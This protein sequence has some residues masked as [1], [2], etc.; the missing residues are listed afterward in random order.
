M[1]INLANYKKDEIIKMNAWKCPSHSHTGLEHPQC[2]LREHG[3]DLK[4]CFFDLESTSLN[5]TFGF[6]LTYSI[7][8]EGDSNVITGT[9]TKKEVEDG[10]YDK[11]IVKECIDALMKFDR[12]YT[13]YGSRFDLPLLRTRALEQGV[14]F[15]IYGAMSQKDIYYIAKYKLKLHSNRLDCVCDLLNISGK[16]HINPKIWR[17]A[18][19]GNKKA[20]DAI[21]E[22]NIADVEVLELVYNKLK[23]FVKEDNKSI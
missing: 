21:L 18:S 15:P 22:H 19:G 2:Y 16:T 6:I 12:V 23:N 9:V 11:R 8:P 3:K 1:T 13:Y 7:K 4:R 17:L 20:I 10:T 5:G 14:E